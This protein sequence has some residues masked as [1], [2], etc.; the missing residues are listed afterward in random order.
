MMAQDADCDQVLSALERTLG[1]GTA[2]IVFS[3]T[4]DLSEPQRPPRPR[5]PLLRRLKARFA[6]ASALSF[7]RFMGW[8]MRTR[9][10]GIEKRPVQ[11]S[12][13]L[14]LAAHRCMYSLIGTSKVTLV[15]RDQ[16]W[17][18]EPGSPVSELTAGPAATAQ[19]LWLLDLVRGITEAKAQGEESLGGQTT[20]RFTAYANLERALRAAPYPMP[21]ANASD[22][23]VDH[24]RLPLELWVDGEGCIRRIHV[25]HSLV[26]MTLDLLELGAPPPDWSRLQTFPE[27][28]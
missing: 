19:P 4:I 26:P 14:D 2:R 27:R 7:L 13:L 23:V 18:G 24:K 20:R 11:H 28:D 25:R 15:V 17:E 10:P 5:G 16:R 3:L 9:V 21:G 1:R 6:Q 22:L 12:G 8:L